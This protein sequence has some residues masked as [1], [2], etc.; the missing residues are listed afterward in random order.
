[1]DE[2]GPGEFAGRADRCFRSQSMPWSETL[3]TLSAVHGV[4]QHSA[5]TFSV[6]AIL[7]GQAGGCGGDIHLV[8][9][10][11]ALSR[12]MRPKLRAVRRYTLQGAEFLQSFPRAHDV[13]QL[14][15]SIFP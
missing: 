4:W 2:E 1:L 11:D 13:A 6:F 15:L 12:S 14:H 8:A 10:Q 7:K 3:H 9:S 5:R